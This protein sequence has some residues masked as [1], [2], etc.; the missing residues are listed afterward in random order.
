MPDTPRTVSELKTIFASNA[1]GDI[2]AQDMRDLVESL[3]NPVA[4][5][6]N[7]FIGF[8]YLASDYEPVA[9]PVQIP[10]DTAVFDTEG[11]L[12]VDNSFVCPAELQGYWAFTFNIDV[13]DS[14]GAATF[15]TTK[16]SADGTSAQG[17]AGVKGL[18]D[19]ATPSYLSC[20]LVSPMLTDYIAYVILQSN[21]TSPIASA[22]F[23][24]VYL[25]TA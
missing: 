3:A 15:F 1:S 12:V 14:D 19:S 8:Q 2:S 25:G 18:T 5:G 23:S 16:L 22:S 24:G 9:S 10:W 13:D 4:G 20:S 6:L 11:G 21:A 17:L 7:R